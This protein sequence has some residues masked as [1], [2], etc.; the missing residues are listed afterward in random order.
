[1][2]DFSL[3]M[4]SNIVILSILMFSIFVSL[5]G[6]VDTDFSPDVKLALDKNRIDIKNGEL[7]QE[8]VTATI[9]RIDNE[10]RDTIFTLKFPDE[11]MSVYPTDIDG[12]RITELRTRPL[13]GEKSK[14]TLQFKV[15]GSKGEAEKA[16]YDL[17]IQLLWNDTKIENQD[18]IVK[19]IVR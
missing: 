2:K 8:F 18:K 10:N 19:M 7:S 14:D 3:N 6:C 4:K 11:K 9:T 1:M 5:C 12:N 17:I 15:Y 13:K 16:E